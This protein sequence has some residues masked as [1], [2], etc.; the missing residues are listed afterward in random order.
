MR[1]LRGLQLAL[2]DVRAAGGEIIVVSKDSP[3]ELA[4]IAKLEGLEFLLL[5]DPE[6]ELVDAFGLRH[7]GADVFRG[8]DISR[9]AVLFFGSNGVLQDRFMTDNWRFRLNTEDAIGRMQLLD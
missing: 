5:S 1:E 2:D 8:G 7:K 9:P 4:Q 3:E 6:L